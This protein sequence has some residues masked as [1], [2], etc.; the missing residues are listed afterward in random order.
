MKRR[1]SK[2]LP[3]PYHEILR[4]L[5]RARVEFIVIGVSGINYFAKDAS[6]VLSTADYDL[7]LKPTP[8]K[9]LHHRRSRGQSLAG[10]ARS[11]GRI[12]SEV[13]LGVK[14][15]VNAFD[16]REKAGYTHKSPRWAVAYKFEAQQATTQVLDIKSSVGRTG[17]VTPVAKLKPVSC[18]GVTISS[19]TLHN[20]DEIK[21]LDVRIGDTVIIQR[22]GDVIP[23]V[24]KVVESLRPRGAK[25]FE[26]PTEC[27]VCDLTH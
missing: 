4:D 7:F 26:M 23:K 19:A 16:L 6:Q 22:A 21:R 13:D 10:F 14:D 12:G 8:E 5:S 9:R 17:A 25:T 18:A 2:S 24:L 3:N 20:F 1:Q 11:F 15:T 27:P